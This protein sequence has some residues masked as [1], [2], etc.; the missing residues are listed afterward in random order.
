MIWKWVIY[1]NLIVKV[2]VLVQFNEI[3]NKLRISFY[4][5][6]SHL[7]KNIWYE[8]KLTE[9]ENIKIKATLWNQIND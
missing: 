3:V 4:I 5:L 8:Y 2:N 1:I 7:T 9:N 6:L